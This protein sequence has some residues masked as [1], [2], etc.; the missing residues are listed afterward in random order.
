MYPL[1]FIVRGVPSDIDNCFCVLSDIINLY[2]VL[3]NLILRQQFNAAMSPKCLNIDQFKNACPNH[4]PSKSFAIDQNNLYT[5]TFYSGI[6]RMQTNE[7][8]KKFARLN[9][10]TGRKR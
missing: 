1:I 5:L 8:Y 7:K 10:D 2:I 4:K 3:P 9:Y 6:I